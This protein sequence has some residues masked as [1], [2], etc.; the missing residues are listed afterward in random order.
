MTEGPLKKLELGVETVP[1]LKE[2]AAVFEK[3]TG[4]KD[5]TE[6]RKL[7]DERGIYLWEISVETE[8]GHAEY[9]YNRAGPNPKG[10]DLQTAVYATYYDRAGGIINGYTI[11]RLTNNIWATGTELPDIDP[12]VDYKNLLP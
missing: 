4:S 5:Y 11:A 1:T 12:S 2:V 9:E 8:D 10:K 7:E 3:L 6:M